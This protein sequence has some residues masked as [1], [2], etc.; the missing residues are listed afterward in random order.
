GSRRTARRPH[1]GRGPRDMQHRRR[2]VWRRIVAL[3]RW[4]TQRGRILLRQEAR[5]VRQLVLTRGP[6]LG[7]E[8]RRPPD[9]LLPHALERDCGEVRRT[10]RRNGVR[11][12]PRWHPR[13]RKRRP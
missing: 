13:R 10:R 2:I 7:P 5:R 1:G 3:S 11:R 8:A 9:A 6:P 4:L 12:R